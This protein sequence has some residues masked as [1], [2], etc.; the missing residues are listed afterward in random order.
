M[1]CVADL[2]AK[3][4]S[5]GGNAEVLVAE[6]ADQIK[7]L[8]RRLLLRHPQCVGLHL[9]F[10]RRAHVRCRAKVAIRRHRTL[11]A[12]MRTL[13]VVVL[14][15][16][17]ETPQAVR[18]VGEHR[19][20]EKLFPQRLPEALD[21]A[22]RLRMLRSTLA[23]RDAVPTQQL[24]KL[25]LAPPRRVL[26]AL[27]GQHLLRL[28][29]LGDAALERFDHQTRFLVMRHRPRHDVAR[30]VVHEAHQVHALMT[31][32]LEGEEVAL[33]EL[34]RRRALE[35]PRRLLAW[36][37]DLG[38]RHQSCLVK[39][40]THCR[41]RHAQTREPREH[42]AN[43][44]RPPL[45]ICLPRRDDRSLHR[46]G[47]PALLAFRRGATVMV[48]WLQ[49]VHPAALKQRHELLHHRRRHPK[50]HRGVS[51]ASASHHRL[52]D[53]DAHRIRHL[54]FASTRTVGQRWCWIS[55][56]SR[57]DRPR[58]PGSRPAHVR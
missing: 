21:L 28:S 41:L 26:P 6:T 53:P 50:R 35:A 48:L 54:S 5:A 11:D 34:I 13:E 55:F 29:V 31:A 56:L 16:E 27:I 17:R 47:S 9:G 25:R 49:R 58:A 44:A 24:L 38:L 46:L 32:Q 1:R 20:T 42:V 57:S 14:D 2:D 40:A 4:A 52:H 15:E 36:R 51:V 19:L 18:E 7:R 8:L 39:N 45:G 23:V 3:R 30:V 43:S 22:E 10:D 37:F 12:L 33:P